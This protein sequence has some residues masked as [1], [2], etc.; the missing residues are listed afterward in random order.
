MQFDERR[1]AYS[2]GDLICVNLL[3]ETEYFQGF[4]MAETT[5]SNLF[6]ALFWKEE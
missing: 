4:S 5:Y 2:S 6:A 3:L 1:N